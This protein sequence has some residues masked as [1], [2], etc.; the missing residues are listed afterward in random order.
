MQKKGEVIT[1]VLDEAGRP[2]PGFT[3]NEAKPVRGRDGLRLRPAWSAGKDLSSLGGQVVRLKF[4]LRNA[5]LYA[6][7]VKP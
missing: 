5:R 2:I 7:Q 1:E 4:H 6:F 3:R